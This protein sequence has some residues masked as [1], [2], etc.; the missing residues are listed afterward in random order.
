MILQLPETSYHL[1]LEAGQTNLL[2]LHVGWI[3]FIKHPS[4][5]PFQHVV[6]MLHVPFQYQGPEIALHWFISEAGVTHV[7]FIV[8]KVFNLSWSLA[9]TS[10]HRKC[11]IVVPTVLKTASHMPLVSKQHLADRQPLFLLSLPENHEPWHCWSVHWSLGSQ[12]ALLFQG[13]TP[14]Y[15][16]RP[17]AGPLSQKSSQLVSWPPQNCL[18]VQL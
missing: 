16:L 5:L 13:F 8:T 4:P 1:P 10:F 7:Y 6:N 11:W 9:Q 14:S 2:N 15:T 18:K 3:C 12:R 17:S